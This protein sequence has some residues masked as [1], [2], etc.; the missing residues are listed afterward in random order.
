MIVPN[1]TECLLVCPSGRG[2]VLLGRAGVTGTQTAMESAS[3]GPCLNGRSATVIVGI[4]YFNPEHVQALD[5]G[6]RGA[7]VGSAIVQIIA[8]NVQDPV[9]R[10]ARLHQFVSSMKAATKTK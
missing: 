5:A 8:E 7:I 4:R 3:T 10:N 6:A 2:F 9:T 1:A